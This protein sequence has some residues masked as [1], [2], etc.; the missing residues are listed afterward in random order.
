M[1]FRVEHILPC[2]TMINQ[3]HHSHMHWA[4]LTMPLYSYF[5]NGWHHI[6]TTTVTH[7]VQ[8]AVT[9]MDA[10]YGIQATK[11]SV[12]SLYS[13]GAMS[14]LCAYVGPN[15]ICLIGCWQSNEMLCYLHVQAFPFVSSLRAQMLHHSSYSLLPKP[16]LRA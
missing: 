14:L 3:V 4:S 10:T 9:A 13:S 12:R 7:P 15:I 8:H 16:I 2:V 6:D 11:I 5:D 1:R